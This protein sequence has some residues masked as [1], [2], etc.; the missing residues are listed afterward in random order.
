MKNVFRSLTTFCASLA[1]CFFI[2]TPIV[3][4]PGAEVARAST[5]DEI[6]KYL[7]TAGDK[8]FGYNTTNAPLLGSVIGK[9]VTA[10]LGF[11]GTIAFIIF[12]YGG[13]L[14][15][16]AR[17]NEEQVAQ[18]QKYLTNGVLGVV[19][20]VLAYS[21]AYFVTSVLYNAARK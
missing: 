2:F 7:N 16:T 9:I 6:N 1:I 5:N 18:A 19:V 3:S 14:W 8:G 21:A 4:V 17:G 20:I 12:L 11:T 15:L 10:I 13:F